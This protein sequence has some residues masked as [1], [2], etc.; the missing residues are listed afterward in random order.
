MSHIACKRWVATT[1]ER[2][3][4]TYLSGGVDD[5]RREILAL[6][7]YSLAEGV[8]YRRVVALHEMT[9]NELHSER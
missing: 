6:P 2:A 4:G 8:F 7:L 1:E 9:V 3:R 5:F